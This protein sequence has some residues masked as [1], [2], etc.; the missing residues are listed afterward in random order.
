[1]LAQPLYNGLVV[2]KARDE[3]SVLTRFNINMFNSKPYIQVKKNMDK[4]L[5]KKERKKIRYLK[6]SKITKNKD[7]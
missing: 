5:N 2:D 6:C 7:E 4:K 3:R 1:M